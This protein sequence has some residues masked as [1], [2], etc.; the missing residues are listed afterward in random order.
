MHPCVKFV[1]RGACVLQSKVIS[2]GRVPFKSQ[3][4]RLV[5]GRAPF[6]VKDTG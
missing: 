4:Y 5:G 2:G 3:R 1:G 6:R